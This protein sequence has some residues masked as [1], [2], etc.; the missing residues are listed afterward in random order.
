MTEN[1]ATLISSLIREINIKEQSVLSAKLTDFGVTPHQAILL[2]LIANKP[3]LIQKDIVDIMQRKAAT[4]SAFL[5][6]LETDGL[7]TRKIPANNTRNK[8]LFITDKGQVVVDAF[9]AARED[10]Y[11]QLVAPLTATQQNDLIELL[12]AIK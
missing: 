5:K 2:S 9:N 3:G 7:L 11:A 6:K 12:R 8:E 1:N 10:V 4:V